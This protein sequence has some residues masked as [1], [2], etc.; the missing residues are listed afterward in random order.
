MK[1]IHK[2]LDILKL[3]KKLNFN[4]NINIKQLCHEILKNKI[5][6]NFDIS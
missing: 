3:K 5:F 6:I 4:V 2:Q 1:K